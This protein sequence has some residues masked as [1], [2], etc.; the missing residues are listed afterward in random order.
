MPT[1]DKR[2]RQPRHSRASP[3]CPAHLLMNWARL[4]MARLFMDWA[5]LLM[6]RLLKD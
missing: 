4:L 6:A 5:R 2:A 3:S 1:D